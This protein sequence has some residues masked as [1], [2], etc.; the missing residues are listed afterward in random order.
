ME[1]FLLLWTFLLCLWTWV[2]IVLKSDD[3][4]LVVWANL[5]KRYD[6]QI[7]IGAVKDKRS[8]CISVGRFASA[9]SEYLG[10]FKIY[11]QQIINGDE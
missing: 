8:D 7:L 6:G 9:K 1:Y 11:K 4:E 3:K 10:T 5:Y 2:I